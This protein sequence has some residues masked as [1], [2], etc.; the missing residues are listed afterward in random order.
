[1]WNQWQGG[2]G[3][4]GGPPPPWGQGPG[5]GFGPPRAGVQ[6]G[7]FGAVQRQRQFPPPPH[8]QQQQHGGGFFGGM[9][10]QQQQQQGFRMPP[11]PPALLRN[12]GS[13][14]PQGRQHQHQHQHQ[15]PRNGKQPAKLQQ[16]K[17]R[18]AA[19]QPKAAATPPTAAAAAADQPIAED[20]V[21]YCD[22]CEK[23]FTSVRARDQHMAAHVKCEQCAF[24]A[25]GKCL[26]TRGDAA[27]LLLS[28]TTHTLSQMMA[29]RNYPRRTL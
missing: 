16:Q 7:A 1:M 21:L 9:Q 11:P 29:L 3:G 17:Q 18:P 2:N 4:G 5:G 13:G 23:E 26:S 24:A 22:P 19:L 12:S 15:Q 20:V 14:M 27:F 28:A 6:W 10:Q 25:S 8:N